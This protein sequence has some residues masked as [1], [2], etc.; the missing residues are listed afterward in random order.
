VYSQFYPTNASYGWL[1]KIRVYINNTDNSASNIL[2]NVTQ[3][4]NLIG[5]ASTSS[6]Q[7]DQ[8]VTFYINENPRLKKSIWNGSVYNNTWEVWF[9]APDAITNSSYK[10]LNVTPEGNSSFQTY[11]T[12]AHG[13][14]NG[15]GIVD[16]KDEEIILQFP[17]GLMWNSTNDWY[18]NLSKFDLNDDKIINYEDVELF[19]EYWKQDGDNT[20]MSPIV[21]SSL[22]IE[23][24]DTN[25][26]EWFGNGTELAQPF[27]ASKTTSLLQVLLNLSM[28]TGNDEDITVKITTE[29][30]GT[31][32]GATSTIDA[33]HDIT[34]EMRTFVFDKPVEIT[35]DL[36]YHIEVSTTGNKPKAYRWY[37]NY[38]E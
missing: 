13:D 23:Q 11:L 3:N 6:F 36:T 8:F 16:S 7:D 31:I 18:S 1:T 28:D 25:Q 29:T 10:I 20:L 9:Y 5:T 27:I 12:T 34:P 24:P 22:L 32:T 4:G 14:Y 21:N 38:Q 30:H 19:N 37:A 2:L 17:D 33:L 15:D 35:K 26:W